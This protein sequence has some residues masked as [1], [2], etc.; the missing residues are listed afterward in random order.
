MP[1]L[2][3]NQQRQST[4]G[5]NKYVANYLVKYLCLKIAMLKKYALTVANRCSLV[6]LLIWRVLHILRRNS[7]VIQLTILQLCQMFTDFKHS[8]ISKLNDKFVTK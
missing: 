4:E 3:P 5:I 2:P 7:K 6:I 1:F 8:F